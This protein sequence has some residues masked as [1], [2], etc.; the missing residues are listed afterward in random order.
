M[1]KIS[2]IYLLD[3]FFK[4]NVL[5]LPSAFLFILRINY[6]TNKQTNRPREKKKGKRRRRE[7]E[8]YRIEKLGDVYGYLLLQILHSRTQY[9]LVIKRKL[10]SKLPV[11]ILTCIHLSFFLF[12]SL[13]PR[14]TSQNFALRTEEVDDKKRLPRGSGGSRSIPYLL[15]GSYIHVGYL[16]VNDGSN[17]QGKIG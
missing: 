1:K 10:L 11:I 16:T 3:F 15:G 8:I 6:M 13:S 9:L 7:R 5:L 17:V 14:K 4:K 2:D 12:L